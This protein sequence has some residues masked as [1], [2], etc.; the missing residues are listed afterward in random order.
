MANHPALEAIDDPDYVTR[1]A[2]RRR[3]RRRQLAVV[4]LVFCLLIL[5]TGWKTVQHL[6]ASS[7]L[8]S[9][10]Y[11]VIW[12]ASGRSWLTGGFT[13]VKYLQRNDMSLNSQ[14]VSELS[15]LPLLHRVEELDLSTAFGL[16]D[17]DLVILDQLRLL[18]DLNISR[19]KQS[20]Y[21]PENPVRLTDA[22]LARL[23]SLKNL[24]R[25]Y[26]NRQGITDVGVAAHLAGLVHL[27]EL[28]L[29][30]TP[31]TD[32]SLEVFQKLTRLQSLDV[33][34]TKISAEALAKFEA[35]RPEVRV[36]HEDPVAS[37]I[38]Q[39]SRPKR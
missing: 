18:R 19:A 23:E 25:L 38:P 5:A 28:E 7:W 34:G 33:S 14:R 12:G 13:S 27:E 1:L 29:R 24:E 36:I 9:N 20:M 4:L 10:H 6:V 37:E 26:L 2:E 35:A 11:R 31:I 17:N 39:P 21:V 22:T 16:S 30:E 32:A 3:G 8:G 15:R